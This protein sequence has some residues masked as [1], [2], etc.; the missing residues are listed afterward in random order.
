MGY[1][2]HIIT[3][4]KIEYAPEEFLNWNNRFAEQA[5]AEYGAFP[6]NESTD[7]G[8]YAMWEIPR[9]DLSRACGKL[10]RAL[11]SPRSEEY[12]D[13]ERVANVV[14]IFGN[15]VRE[16]LKELVEMLSFA[17]DKSATGDYIYI[18]WF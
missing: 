18:E 16:K 6:T 13:V 12:E 7:N 2:A 9:S 11:S 10:R 4:R 5:L 15:D 1:R 14:G 17:L 3:R 8:E